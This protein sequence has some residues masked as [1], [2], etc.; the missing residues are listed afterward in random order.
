MNWFHLLLRVQRISQ[1]W[2]LVV[3]CILYAYRSFFPFSCSQEWLDQ[4]CRWNV[5]AGPRCG[6]WQWWTWSDH[7]AWL[8]IT[9]FSKELCLRNNV[10]G[11]FSEL[12][13]R[14][15]FFIRKFQNFPSKNCWH[16]CH[17]DF[18]SAYMTSSGCDANVSSDNELKNSDSHFL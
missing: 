1:Q 4:E 6:V 12:F 16:S 5:G 7:I 10:S 15:T 13:L 3:L 17:L 11:I 8:M 2:A 14:I 9:M 18:I